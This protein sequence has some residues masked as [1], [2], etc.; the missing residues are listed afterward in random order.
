MIAHLDFTATDVIQLARK[1][2]TV[3]IV[4]RIAVARTATLPPDTARVL[5]EPTVNA[6]S[7][8]ARSGY[9]E[10][11]VKTNVVAKAELAT[12]KPDT[13]TVRQERRGNAARGIVME[14]G[15]VKTAVVLVSVKTPTLATL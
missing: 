12:P 3:K 5:R 6:A 1:G 9:G 13:A 8:N 2:N 14:C 15:M 10:I 11:T 4:R 7:M